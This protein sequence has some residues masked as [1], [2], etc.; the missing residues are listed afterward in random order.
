MGL[1]KYSKYYTRM[2]RTPPE[3]GEAQKRQQSGWA[4]QQ[5]G[6]GWATVKKSHN[7]P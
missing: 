6:T 7:E 3:G 5:G 4:L 1:T 2:A